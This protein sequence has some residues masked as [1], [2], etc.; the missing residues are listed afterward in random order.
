MD[1]L[2]LPLDSIIIVSL[3]LVPDVLSLSIRIIPPP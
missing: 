2:G 3:T 1:R